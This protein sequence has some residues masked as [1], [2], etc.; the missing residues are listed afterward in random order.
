[1]SSFA[2]AGFFQRLLC[3]LTSHRWVLDAGRCARCG[4]VCSHK[5]AIL[6]IRWGR[7][8]CR[9]CLSLMPPRKQTGSLVTQPYRKIR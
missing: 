2:M 4:A 7:G 3:R 1:M 5:V 8:M 6:D 9:E